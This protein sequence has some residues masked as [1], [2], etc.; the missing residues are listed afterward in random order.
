MRAYCNKFTLD[1]ENVVLI[2]IVVTLFVFLFLAYAF[3]YICVCLCAGVRCIHS[4]TA[5]K[6]LIC[7]L[8]W[9]VVLWVALYT[10]KLWHG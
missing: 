1:I 9:C 8:K 2:F 10:A 4:L 5:W 3:V 6:V 7:A